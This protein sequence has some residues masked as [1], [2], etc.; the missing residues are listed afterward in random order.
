MKPNAVL[1]NTSRGQVV[2]ERALASA[3][4]EGRIAAAGID[5][6]ATSPPPADSPL[7]KLENVVITPHIASEY[8]Q[9]DEDFWHYSV[10]AIS[11]MAQGHLPASYVNPRVADRSG[12]TIR[13]F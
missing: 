9:I 3:L 7:R 12:F 13:D 4:T 2:D 11:D 5:V 1:I 6:F 8:D 10:E